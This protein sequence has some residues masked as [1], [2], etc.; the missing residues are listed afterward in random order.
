MQFST[1]QTELIKARIQERLACGHAN[2]WELSFLNDMK[3]RF[4]RYGNKTRLSDAQY[5]KLDKFLKLGDI[6]PRSQPV[7]TGRQSDDETIQH[8]P[9]TRPRNTRSTDRPRNQPNARSRIPIIT[10]ISPRRTV[11]RLKRKLFSVVFV[12]MG[13]FALVGAALEPTSPTQ[14]ADTA[15]YAVVT[16][17]RVNQRE[18]PSTADR[19]MGQLAEGARVRKVSDQGGWSQIVSTLGTGWMSSSFLSPNGAAVTERATNKPVRPTPSSPLQNVG[20]VQARDIRVIDGDT[21]AISGQRANVRLVGFNTPETRSPSCSA[22]L[23][24]G[25]RATA[26]LKALVTEARSIEFKRV[27]CAC[28][29]GTEGTNRCNFGRQC[30]TLLV[31]GTDVGNILISERLAVPYKCGA[32]RCPPRPGNWCQ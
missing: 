6:G 28:R 22:E 7:S 25:Q 3:Q 5:S 2:D 18:G 10:G 15:T 16:G 1:K 14:Q 29:P 4:N 8:V 17:S 13:F 20:A 26:R 32:T 27:A 9:Q 19:V 30:G 31:D 12:I 11:R 21:V 23:A 24:T